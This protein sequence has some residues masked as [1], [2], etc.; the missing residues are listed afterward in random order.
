MISKADSSNLVAFIIPI[1]HQM[2]EAA[3][4]LSRSLAEYNLYLLKFPFSEYL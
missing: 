2:Q 3:L 1:S 4:S